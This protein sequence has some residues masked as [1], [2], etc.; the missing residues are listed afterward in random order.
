MVE[1]VE[2]VPP[3]LVRVVLVAALLDDDDDDDNIFNKASVGCV[4]KVN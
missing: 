1:E 4:G 2:P 3:P